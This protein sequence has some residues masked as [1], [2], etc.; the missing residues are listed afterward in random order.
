[1]EE[2]R[3]EMELGGRK[4][5]V[6]VGKVAAQANGAVLIS[7]GETTVLATATA[8]E[9]PREGIDFFP[10]SVDF[11]EKMY[12]VGKMPGGF[13][14]RE[15]K[16]SEN[17]VLTSRVIDRPMRPLFPKDYRNDVTLDTLVLSVDPDCRP[18]IVAMNGAAIAT[19]ISDIPFDGPVAMTQLGMINGELIINPSQEQWDKGDLRYENTFMTT[20][21]NANGS[22]NW[23]SDG[24]YA[25]YNS[26]DTATQG[27][28]WKYFPYY[29]S[30]AE[31]RAWM[32]AHQPQ[33]VKGTWDNQPNAYKIC[34]AGN[35]NIITY[36]MADDG[37]IS[38]ESTQT[39]EDALE[40]SNAL[41]K[42]PCVRKWDD[43]TSGFIDGTNTTNDYRDIILLHRSDIVLV[44][45]EAAYMLGQIGQAE[46]YL[47]NVRNRAG[48]AN[49]TISAYSA[50]YTVSAGFEDEFHKGIDFI[51]DERARELYAENER[52]M[53]LR[54]TKQLVRYNIEFNSKISSLQDMSDDGEHAKLYRPIPQA[55]INANEAL[56]A[57]DQN[58]GY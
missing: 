56:T 9:K 7:Y 47:N 28:R 14:K 21:Y 55:E 16:A 11:E 37:T 36:K 50:K 22:D 12:A 40:G 13:N 57:A 1:M 38:V 33:M 26:A 54:R 39:Y 42:F 35:T 17:A 15:G 49:T 24:Y 19:T 27:I 51:L 8:S 48:F 43:A 5:S 25:Y 20:F 23:G 18:E 3:F 29:V 34:D 30:D 2:K 53:D 31:I 4:L 58:L 45:A 52:W 32:T 6:T 10:L 46:G 41:N 44:A